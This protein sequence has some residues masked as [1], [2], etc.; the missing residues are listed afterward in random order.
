MSTYTAV[1][2]PKNEFSL[3]NT[4][5]ES[6]V[7]TAEGVLA[8]FKKMHKL[9]VIIDDN[10]NGNIGMSCETT[11]PKTIIELKSLGFEKLS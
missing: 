3:D 7:M 8:D 5:I 1:Y 4:N 6:Y 9:G 10:Q 2:R 11:D